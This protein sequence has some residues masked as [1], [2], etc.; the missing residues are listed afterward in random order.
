M[1]PIW[2]ISWK[3]DENYKPEA[4]IHAFIL[5]GASH[6][7]IGETSN[8]QHR[9]RWQNQDLHEI[10]VCIDR[11]TS[12]LRASIH[13]WKQS[14]L[15]IETRPEDQFE[16]D[17]FT[18]LSKQHL[19]G[20]DQE[21]DH[22]EARLHTL[23][24]TEERD[25]PQ[26]YHS[27]ANRISLQQRT[28][29]Q[30]WVFTKV[31]RMVANGFAAQHGTN[32]STPSLRGRNSTDASVAYDQSDSDWDEANKGVTRALLVL[33]SVMLFATILIKVFAMRQSSSSGHIQ[34]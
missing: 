26:N 31:R 14:P 1:Q 27:S 32:S 34:I 16:K 4:N 12:V 20:I 33:V 7:R 15:Q 28:A 24:N 9:G 6:W 2:T 19:L 30:D 17:S 11:V 3:W 25:T 8:E 10:I 23:R 5:V 29:L 18:P 13:S 21:P 22:D